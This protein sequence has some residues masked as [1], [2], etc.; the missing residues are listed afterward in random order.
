[1]MRNNKKAAIELSMNFLVVIIIS[2]VI[3]GLGMILF[4]NLKGNAE[5][6]KDT[7]DQQTQEQLKALMLNNNY[8]V[9]VY[10]NQLTIDNGKGEMVGL[11]IKNEFNEKREFTIE[12]ISVKYY[13]TSDS[14]ADDI[15]TWNV[16]EQTNEIQFYQPSFIKPKEQKTTGILIKMP[17]NAVSGEYVVT[18]K[19]LEG[20]KDY[21]VVKIYIINP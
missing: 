19:I 13:E 20:S 4:F 14:T 1:M 12:L 8:K 5:D 10:P 18:L 7:I 11:G 2:I 21:G 9:A 15:D 3:V 16:N 17:S 6:Y